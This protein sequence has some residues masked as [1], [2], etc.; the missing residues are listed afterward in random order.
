MPSCRRRWTSLRHASS[1]PS[2]TRPR[3]PLP[4]RHT[5]ANNTDV[6]AEPAFGDNPLRR[7]CRCSCGSPHPV[8]NPESLS[9]L[10]RKAP[11]ARGFFFALIW[12]ALVARSGKEQEK[13]VLCYNGWRP[14]QRILEIKI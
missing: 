5:P 8:C 4:L 2:S 14:R 1:P 13:D 6:L 10:G 12:T 7:P 3:L 11:I 9:P